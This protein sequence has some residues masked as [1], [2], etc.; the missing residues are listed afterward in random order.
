MGGGTACNSSEADSAE[1]CHNYSFVF[2]GIIKYHFS[3]WQ[4]KDRWDHSQGDKGKKWSLD[5]QVALSGRTS[6]KATQC[7]LTT[8]FWC[9][10]WSLESN[11][12]LLTWTEDPFKATI[13]C[14]WVND[15][16][17]NGQSRLFQTTLHCSAADKVAE[18]YLSKNLFVYV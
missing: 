17:Q 3:R 10:P 8:S 6:V 4:L 1:N 2:Y 7:K 13:R 15:L 16:F 9:G 18:F 12:L 5:H 11:P 14:K